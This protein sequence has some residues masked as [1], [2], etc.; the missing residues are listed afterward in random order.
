MSDIDETFESISRI[1]SAKL[2]AREVLSVADQGF[3]I[4]SGSTSREIAVANYLARLK[5]V[6]S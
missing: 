5:Q 4:D 2:A 6:E 1:I 3:V